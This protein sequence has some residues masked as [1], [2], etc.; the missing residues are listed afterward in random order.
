MITATYPTKQ[1]PRCYPRALLI[2]FDRFLADSPIAHIDIIKS[3]HEA[4]DTITHYDTTSGLNLDGYH[5][6]VNFG[7]LK[8]DQEV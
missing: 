5:I 2:T 6:F 1:N 7:Y 3:L 8:A 4:F